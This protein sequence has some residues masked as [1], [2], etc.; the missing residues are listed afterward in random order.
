M[1]SLEPNF[2]EIMRIVKSQE[3][4]LLKPYRFNIDAPTFN[5]AILHCNFISHRDTRDVVRSTIACY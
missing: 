2:Q 5:Y 1:Q 4:L 3:R